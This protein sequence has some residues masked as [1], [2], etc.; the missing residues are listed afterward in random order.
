MLA[1]QPNVATAF[2]EAVWESGT[3]Y[4]LVQPVIDHLVKLRQE[5]C[6]VSPTHAAYAPDLVYS[7]GGAEE[8]ASEGSRHPQS[9]GIYGQ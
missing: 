5:L 7:D 3:K 9:P 2:T 4:T 8:G 1:L 6:K